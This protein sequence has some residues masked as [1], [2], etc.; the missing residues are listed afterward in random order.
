MAKKSG[1]VNNKNLYLIPNLISDNFFE[2]DSGF[3]R[4]ALGISQNKKVILYGADHA[5]DNPYKGFNYFVD[6]IQK[7]KNIGINSNQVQILFYGVT[8]SSEIEKK[9]PFE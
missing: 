1:V 9:F 5:L 2:I 6:V 8:K 4:K 7:L 3:A